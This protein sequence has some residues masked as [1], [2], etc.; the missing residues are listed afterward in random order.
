VTLTVVNRSPDAGVSAL[1][2]AGRPLAS[3][4]ALVHL[5]HGPSPDAKNSF[6]EPDLVGVR[7]HSVPASGIEFE[8]S[9]PPHSFS[10]VELVLQ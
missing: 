7:T 10:C 9:L 3:T 1:V 2:S 6:S 8:L 4:G 5:V